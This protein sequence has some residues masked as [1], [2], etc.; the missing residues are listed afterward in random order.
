MSEEENRGARAAVVASGDL[1]GRIVLSRYRVLCLLARGGMGE[2][3][4]ARNEGAS[5]FHRPV[6]VKRV[7]AEHAS[8]PTIVG[9]FRREARVMSSLREPHIVSV[10]DFA[11]DHGDHLMAI[12]YVH[13]FHLGRWLKWTAM[14]RP[15]PV[16][17][18]IEIVLGVLAALAH[19]HAATGP[20][21]ASL[22]IVHRDV[23]PANVLIDVGGMVKL[24]DF[25]VARMQGEHTEVA[26]GEVAV[27][28]KFPYLAPELFDAT[29]ATPGTDTYAAAVLLDEILRGVNAFRGAKVTDTITR[30]ARMVPPSLDKVRG[31]V[32]PELA[33]VVAKAIAKK[34]ADRF[35]SAVELAAA[36]REVRSTSADEAKAELA[37]AAR[38][39]FL[40]PEMARELGVP[41][42]SELE[43]LW[44]GPVP[45]SFTTRAP[46]RV[47]EDDPTLAARATPRPRRGPVS[48]VIGIT[49]AIAVPAAIAIAYIATQSPSID[50]AAPVVIA[51]DRASAHT[52]ADAGAAHAPVD[53]ALASLATAPAA[54]AIAPEARSGRAPRAAIEAPFRARSAQISR[55]FTDHVQSLEGTP[56]LD[57]HFEIGVDGSVERA[58]L[59]PAAVSSTTLGACLLDVARTTHFAAQP[60]P[61]SFHVPLGARRVGG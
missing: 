61:V 37:S 1:V 9:L 31:E 56:E 51:I 60:A 35:A 11:E 52:A 20:D 25:G 15:F 4:L 43:A 54:T 41:Q 21:G 32:S 50:D 48:H 40:D 7:L 55:C 44:H 42:L 22:G 10:L 12:E 53:A 57:V 38:A 39:D 59:T 30:V 34:P 5:G 13:G 46:K 28:G 58:T 14:R 26:D 27:R 18:A 24:A 33:R 23:S 8:N 29:A 6:V 16:E 3:Y 2:V 45:T 36:L 49:A 47:S 19:A 17:R